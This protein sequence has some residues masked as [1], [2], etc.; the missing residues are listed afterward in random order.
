[1]LQVFLVQSQQLAVEVVGAVVLQTVALAA[2]LE[3]VII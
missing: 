1:V 2:V 3:V